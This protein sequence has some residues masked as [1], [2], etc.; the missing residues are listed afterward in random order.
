ME[1]PPRTLESEELLAALRGEY[2]PRVLIAD[3]LEPAGIELLQKAGIDVD[4]RPGLQGDDLRDA[5]RAADAPA[6]ECPTARPHRPRRQHRAL[7]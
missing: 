2:L 6:P 4:Y 7:R 3:K 1:A 5:L